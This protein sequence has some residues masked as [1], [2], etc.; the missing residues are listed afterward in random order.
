[1]SSDAEFLQKFKILFETLRDHPDR[2]IIVELSKVA[3]ANIG[4]A[5]V[6]SNTVVGRLIHPTTNACFKLPIFYLMDSLMKHVGG[7]YK[8]LFEALFTMKDVYSVVFNGVHEKDREKLGFLMGTW[9]DRRFLSPN[10]LTVL[11]AQL[12]LPVCFSLTICKFI[13]KT[14][15][16]LHILSSLLGQ[17]CS[18]C[19]SE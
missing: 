15:R 12:T 5:T 2:N 19:A 16:T 1:M 11:K 3:E 13:I 7:P 10:L 18:V 14:F 9:D 6:I 4:R 17:Y 8:E